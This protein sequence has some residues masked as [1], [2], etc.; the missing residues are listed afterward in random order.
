LCNIHG[1]AAKK[2]GDKVELPA[3][4]GTRWAVIANIKA[5]TDLEVV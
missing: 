3:E 2:V 1:L 5:F 4:Q